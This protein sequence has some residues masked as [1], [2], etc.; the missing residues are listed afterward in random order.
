VVKE[1]VEVKEDLNTIH[2]RG[3]P[4]AVIAKKLPELV[5]RNPIMTESVVLLPQGI[6]DPV[7]AEVEVLREGVVVGTT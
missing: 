6:E 3:K 2:Q 5:Q 4:T 7:A 1:K